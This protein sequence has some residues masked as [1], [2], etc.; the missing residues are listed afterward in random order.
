MSYAVLLYGAN[1]LLAEPTFNDAPVHGPILQLRQDLVQVPLLH[2][3]WHFG[4]TTA[5]VTQVEPDHLA[6]FVLLF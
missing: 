3:L 6:V 1:L 5:E 2:S 4:E